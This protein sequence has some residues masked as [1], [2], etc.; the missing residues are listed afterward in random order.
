MMKIEALSAERDQLAAEKHR[1]MLER[2]VQQL[3]RD[4]G[5]SKG[6]QEAI[7]SDKYERISNFFGWN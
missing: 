6:M 4:T 3:K 1:Q 5:G 2:E 7:G